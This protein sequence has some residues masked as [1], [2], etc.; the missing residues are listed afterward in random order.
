MSAQLIRNVA[1]LADDA[2]LLA[3]DAALPA[4][5]ALV[6]LAR[7]KAER[8]TLPVDRIGV[9][10]PNTEDIVELWP[11][12]A[13]ATLIALEFPKSADGRAFSQARL[14]RQRCGYRGELRA[15]GEV[16]R[17]QLQFM[18]RCGFDAYLLRADQNGEA[19]LQA[20][21]DFGMAYQNAADTLPNVFALR[22]QRA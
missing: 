4:G 19:C 22:R 10:V 2:P 20:F 18:Q 6:S 11:T 17:D 16:L 5:R 8:A 21:A 14:L 9:Q 1:L 15:V 3:D 12:L 13:G 7:W